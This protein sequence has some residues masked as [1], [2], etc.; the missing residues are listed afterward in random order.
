MN[1]Y[2]N[3]NNCKQCPQCQFWVQRS[4][5]CNHMTCRCKFEFCYKCGKAYANGDSQCECDLFDSDDEEGEYGEY[6]DEMGV[7][8]DEIGGFED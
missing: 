3:K 7:Y 5:G 1:N 6:G 2:L 8:G 4:E